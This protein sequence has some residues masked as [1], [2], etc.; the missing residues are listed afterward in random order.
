[1]E[2]IRGRDDDST[3]LDKLARQVKRLEERLAAL[4]SCVQVE[5]SGQSLSLKAPVNI[6]IEAGAQMEIKGGSAMTLIGSRI[7]LN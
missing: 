6:T 4:T 3:G 5:D 7:D 1:M 2:R